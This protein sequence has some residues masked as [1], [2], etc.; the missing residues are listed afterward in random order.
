MIKGAILGRKLGMDSIFDAEGNYIPVTVIEAG[1][2]KVLQIKTQEKDGYE[3]VKVA[4]LPKK[5]QRTSKPQL[6][7][8]K[9]AGV[10][11]HYHLREFRA[12]E[13]GPYSV[14]DSVSVEQFAEGD[15]VMV[16]ATSKGRGFAGGVRRHG[17]S[18]GPKTHGQSD[19][20]RAPGSIGQSS[21][22]SRVFK[23]MRMPGRMGNHR[24]SVKNLRVV[25][26]LPEKNLLLVRGAV[27]GP[28]KG[29]VEIRKLHA[30]GAA[31][32]EDKKK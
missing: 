14:G 7:E 13:G 31:Q 27:P 24:V 23:G 26:V 5:P 15:R 2:C 19:R 25:Q 21:Y 6:G 8:F 10:D 4:F 11:P 29:I 18:G 32:G 3:A 1:P 16:T 28:L 22:P 12:L 20:H 9:A 17:F 30:A